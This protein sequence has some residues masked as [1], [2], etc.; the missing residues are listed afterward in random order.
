[1]ILKKRASGMPTSDAFID[2]YQ[3]YRREELIRR[4]WDLVPFLADPMA[5]DARI[6]AVSDGGVYDEPLL[7]AWERRQAEHAD[8]E[9]D[10]VRN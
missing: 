8:Q 10:D 3:D 1:M 7:E 4:E 9:R 2:G 5:D 6:P